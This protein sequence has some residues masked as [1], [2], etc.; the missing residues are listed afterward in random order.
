MATPRDERRVQLVNL[1]KKTLISMCSH[2][3]TRPDGSVVEFLGDSHRT[4]TKDDLIARILEIQFP[5]STG[6]PH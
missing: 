4:W 1:S 2:G 6:D 5:A 3:I